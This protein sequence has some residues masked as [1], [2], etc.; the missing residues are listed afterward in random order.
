MPALT[1]V[2]RDVLRA[3]VDTAVP[4]IEAE[5]DPTG[6]WA[7]PGSATGAD[8]ALAQYLE[9]LP[10]ADRTGVA[11]LLDGLA[12]LG[13]QHQGRATREGMLATAMA[14]APEALVAVSTLRGGA[15]MLAHSITDAEGRNP[16]WAQYGYPGPQITPPRDE[17]YIT[18]HV[19]ADGEV[20]EADVVVVGSGAGGGTIAGVLAAAGRSVVVLEAGGATSERDYRQLEA[21][22]KEMMYRG[23]LSV[24]ADGNVGLLAGYTLGGGTTINWHN[25]VRPSDAV[26]REWAR[27]HGLDGLDTA[28]F[29]RHLEAVLARMGANDRCSD[30]NGP[31]QRMAEGAKALGWS[32]HTAVRNVDEATYDPVAAGYTQF[33][34]PSGSKRGT[35]TTYLRDVY[36]HGAKI[37]VRT[38]ADRVLTEGGRAVGVEAVHTDPGSGETRRVTVRAADVVVACGALETPAL[39]LRS[40]IGGPAVGH[41]LY[42]HPS[43]GIFGVYPED[44]RAWWG[45]PQA[46]IMDEF[47]DL[48]DGYGLLVEGS[49]YYTGV[50]AFQ[51]A[52]RDGREA[53]EAMS[54]LGR[55]ADF[56]FVLRDHAGGRVTI[57][58]DG[59]AVHTYALTDERDVAA[60]R[61][62]LRILAEL[63]LAAGAEELWFGATPPVFRRG[64]DFEAWMANL[65]ATHIGAGGLFMGSAH[66]MGTAR[67]GTDPQTSVAKPTGELHDVAGVWIGDTSA[68]PTPS[69][70]NPMLTCMALARRTAGHIAGHTTAA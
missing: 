35:L 68:F 30:F 4:A 27:E 46:A 49:H 20:I 47:R 7:T 31:H 33:G 53:K 58:G 43:A 66:Q 10:E 5:D 44:Q 16:F 42:L 29:D 24:S 12:M 50:F 23:G 17:P 38:R 9:T 54:K 13:F 2:Q 63:H 32:M 52:R 51:L 69:G 64:D 60:Y 70:A 25:C 55:M 59:E 1:P 22:G 45:P 26:R 34:D 61:K 56:L 37:L 19:P 41:N 67:M 11:Q 48:G 62:G 40:G 14:L 21:E 15:C 18:P 3:L 57:D 36:D 6:F 65:D 39:L 8:E 28:E